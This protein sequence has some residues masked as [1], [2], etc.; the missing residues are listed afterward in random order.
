MSQSPHLKTLQRNT[1][2]DTPTQDSLHPQNTNSPTATTDAPGTLNGLIRV[3][4]DGS[5]DPKMGCGGWAFIA[6]RIVNDE[7]SGNGDVK[8]GIEPHGATSNRMAMQA[9]I[10][11]LKHIPR[12]DAAPITVYS[13]SQIIIDGMTKNAE[14]WKANGWKKSDGKPVLNLDL[15]K[16]ILSAATGRNVTWEMVKGHAGN[17]QNKRAKALAQDALRRARAASFAAE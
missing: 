3:W 7:V 5:C 12:N 17:A 9:A 15:W 13:D 16:Q 8:T 1:Q 11:A 10:E 2:M 14:V 6:Q 4:A